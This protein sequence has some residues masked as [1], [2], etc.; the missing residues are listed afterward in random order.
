[1]HIKAL[2]YDPA[3][4]HAFA[5]EKQRLIDLDILGLDAIH[6]IGSTA[7]PGITAKPVIDI[8]LEVRALELLELHH[9][10]FSA[11]GY[12]ALGEFGVQGRR[13]Y[14]KIGKSL[15]IHIHAFQ[16]GNPQI[17]K[18]IAFRDYL[19]QHPKVRDS[20]KSIKTRATHKNT[21]SNEHYGGGKHDF[22][23]HHEKL[24]LKW[25]QS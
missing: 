11:L 6:H 16:S 1:M 2:P 22:I 19:R 12:E 4:T 23:Q 10:D 7:V 20:Y 13:Y 5:S 17:V 21:R 25:Y 14:R 3:W 9:K 18:N 8:L 15:S 24:A